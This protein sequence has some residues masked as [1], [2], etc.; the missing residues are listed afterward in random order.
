MEKF[1]EQKELAEQI[2]HLTEAK[3]LTRLRFLS[4]AL[5]AIS[6]KSSEED[7]L[8]A[9]EKGCIFYNSKQLLKRYQ[10]SPDEVAHALVHS[11]LHLLMGHP[12][13]HQEK[14][15]RLWNLAC[16]MSVE[17]S[18]WELSG[19]FLSERYEETRVRQLE[20]F[21]DYAG[22]NTAE[23]FYNYFLDNDI[24]KDEQKEL[25]PLFYLDSHKYWEVPGKSAAQ[26][27]RKTSGEFNGDSDEEE[28]SE[29]PAAGVE[30]SE[31]IARKEKHEKKWKQL[32]RQVQ[33]DLE[34]FQRRQGICAGS[35]IQ[36]MKPF[37]F[38]TVDYTAF[39]RMFAAENEVLQISDEEFD[40]IYYTYG[41]QKYGNIPLIE[42]LEYSNLHR[43]REFIIAIDTSGSVQGEIVA[44]FLRQTVH[45]LQQTAS[46]TDQVSIYILQCDAQIQNCIQIHELK[47][48]DAYIDH[49]ELHGF[50]GT[51]FRPVF[52]YVAQLLEQKK[53][54]KING[55]L[56]FTDGAGVYPETE[57]PY[58]TAFIFNRDDYSS[59]KVPEWAIRAVLTSDN[60]RILKK[61]TK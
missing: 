48:L 52:D 2:L 16:D 49:L 41:L 53:L 44:E 55:L 46:F 18:C 11:L 15:V 30:A 60:I 24:S 35:L 19:Y 4:G 28:M 23:A 3:L 20:R 32:A 13:C 9:T 47:E 17:Y 38:E 5:T 51:D 12:F 34:L 22:G 59:P 37:L 25:E 36:G 61:N 29:S 42:P 26:G 14:D 27:G 31:E 57:P 7:V 43:I 58:K 10:K 6:Y 56:Y 33:T 40:P 54:K 50:G 45:V 8:F 1:K 39:L 21:V